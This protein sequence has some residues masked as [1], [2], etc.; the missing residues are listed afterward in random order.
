MP[1]S[2]CSEIQTEPSFRVGDHVRVKYRG[3]E[4]TIIDINGNLIMVSLDDVNHVDSY[5]ASELEKA[6]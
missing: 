6:W 3:Q 1:F 4:G 2:V 5:E